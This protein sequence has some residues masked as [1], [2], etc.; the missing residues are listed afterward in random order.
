MLYFCTTKRKIYSG[1]I[2]F[3]LVLILGLAIILQVD[4]LSAK[5]Q[6]DF[7]KGATQTQRIDFLKSLGYTPDSSYSEQTK[8][9]EIPYVFSDVYK[10]YNELQVSA[11]FDLY[12]FSGKKVKLYTLKLDYPHRNDVYANLLLYDGEIIGGDITALSFSDGF[13]IPLAKEN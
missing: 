6:T 3:M 4:S 5:A 7:P 12:Q 13:M 10:E 11:G 9:V 1:L 2:V 8:D